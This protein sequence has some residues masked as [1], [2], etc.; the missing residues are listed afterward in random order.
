MLFLLQVD[1]C[2]I[3]VAKVATLLATVQKKRHKVCPP[4]PLPCT[5]HAC[6]ADYTPAIKRAESL[7]D[8][9]GIVKL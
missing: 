9:H 2:V 3:T 7:T 5:S 6:I 8:K 4:P 1:R